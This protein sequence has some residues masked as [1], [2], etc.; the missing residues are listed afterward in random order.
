MTSLTSFQGVGGL[1]KFSV[2]VK[3]SSMIKSSLIYTMHNCKTL[4]SGAPPVHNCVPEACQ[5]K[6]EPM[7]LVAET[8]SKS[9]PLQ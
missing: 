9:Y 7:Y 3:K 6:F 5:K 8:A 4:S 2:V 1:R